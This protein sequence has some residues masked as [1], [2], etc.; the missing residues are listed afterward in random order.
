MMDI[1]EGLQYV[2]QTRNDWTFAIHG[3]GTTGCHAVLDNLIEDGDKVLALI[4]G[5]WG[6]LMGNMSTRLGIGNWS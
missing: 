3:T 5:Y 1:K 2:L 6:E 4:N